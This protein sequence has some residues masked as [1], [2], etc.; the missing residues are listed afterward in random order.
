M[1]LN[2]EAVNS[3]VSVC[4]LTSYH[5]QGIAHIKKTMSTLGSITLAFNLYPFGFVRNKQPIEQTFSELHEKGTLNKYWYYY[6]H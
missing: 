4:L 2:P 5:L 6:H 3:T 1:Q